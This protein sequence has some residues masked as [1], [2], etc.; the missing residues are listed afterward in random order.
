MLPQ[1]AQYC[2]Y[3]L[4]RR[5]PP[6]L[7]SLDVGHGLRLALQAAVAALRASQSRGNLPQCHSFVPRLAY[8]AVVL[9]CALTVLASPTVGE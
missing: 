9:L 6:F 7:P 8:A 4:I 1:L 5:G 2:D 3:N